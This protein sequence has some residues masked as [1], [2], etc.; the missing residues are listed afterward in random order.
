M[1]SVAVLIFLRLYK[2]FK[3]FFKL[4]FYTWWVLAFAVSSIITTTHIQYIITSGSRQVSHKLKI[5]QLISRVCLASNR[6]FNS[7][8][9]TAETVTTVL[10]HEH[11]KHFYQCIQLKLVDTDRRSSS[12]LSCMSQHLLIMTHTFTLFAY[13]RDFEIFYIFSCC[14]AFIFVRFHIV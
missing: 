11:G 3:M 14:I 2:S 7:C 5:F 6:C 12:T 1:S 9:A 13:C 4:W 10:S 8:I